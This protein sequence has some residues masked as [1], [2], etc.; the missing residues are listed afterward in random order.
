MFTIWINNIKNKLNSPYSTSLYLLK[1]G[2]IVIT[3]GI[4]LFILREL[5]IGVISGLLILFGLF[6]WYIA[7]QN[8]KNNL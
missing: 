4:C 5:I 2:A 3:I 6:I 8:W 1:F 7:Y